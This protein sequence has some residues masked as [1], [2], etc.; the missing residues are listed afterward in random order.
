MRITSDIGGG[1]S[2]S[3]CVKGIIG[4]VIIALTFAAMLTISIRNR[5]VTVDDAIGITLVLLIIWWGVGISARWALEE[6]PRETWAGPR[7]FYIL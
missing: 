3:F 2:D 5:H 1:V 7:I 6:G 4:L